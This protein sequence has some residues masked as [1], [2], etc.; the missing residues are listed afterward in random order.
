[1]VGKMLGKVGKGPDHAA[2]GRP[3]ATDA[4]RSPEGFEIYYSGF[5]GG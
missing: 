2:I 4:T 5:R 3:S 1:M